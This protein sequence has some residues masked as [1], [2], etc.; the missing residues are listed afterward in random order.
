MRGAGAGGGVS[1]SDWRMLWS[2]WEG[3]AGLVGGPG[4][5][6]QGLR[7]PE[8]TVMPAISPSSVLPSSP[9]RPLGPS[10]G[11]PPHPLSVPSSFVAVA[12]AHAWMTRRPGTSFL[13]P[14]CCP[15]S[16]MT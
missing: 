7:V 8:G 1:L 5:A 2:G 9:M 15:G 11:H 6:R 4:W 12:L 3:P 10:A 13:S 14:P 16:C